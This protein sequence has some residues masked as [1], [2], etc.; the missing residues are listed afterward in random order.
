MRLLQAQLLA[1][2]ALLCTKYEKYQA[3]IFM[4]FEIWFTMN[5]YSNLE[6]VVTKGDHYI[7]GS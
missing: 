3:K 4:P 7:L 5:I 1:V 2:T 6:L